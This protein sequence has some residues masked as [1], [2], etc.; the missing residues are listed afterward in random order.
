[1]GIDEIADQ[2][3]VAGIHRERAIRMKELAR[4]FKEKDVEK[5]L[6]NYINRGEL[7]VARREL[8]KLPGIGRKTADVI[9]LMYYRVPTFPVDTHIT[10]ITSRLG[11][12]GNLSYNTIRDFWM[13]NTSPE[14]YLSL[15]LLLIEHGRRTCKS[16]RP[17]CNRCCIRELC[18]FCGGKR[19]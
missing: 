10:R 11:Y 17:L 13:K 15:H 2:I 18:N 7:D 19:V 1:M 5:V 6:S 8:L 12:V 4:T 9:L 16:R 14:H 3:R